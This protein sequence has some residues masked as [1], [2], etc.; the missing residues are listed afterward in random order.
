[1]RHSNLIIILLLTFSCSNQKEITE[2]EKVLGKENSEAL[3]YLVNDFES[4]YLKR[5]YPNIG[6]KKAYSQFLKEL[7]TGQTEYLQNISENSREYFEKST[8]KLEIYSVLDSIWIERNPKKLTSNIN[9]NPTLNIK[10][11][12]LRPDGTYSYSTSISS[13][14]DGETIDEDSIINESQKNWMDINYD[15]RYSLALNAISNKSDFLEDYLKIRDASGKIDPRFI[16]ERML[17]S[18][19]DLNEYLIKRLIITEIVY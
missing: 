18:K 14:Q 17:K 1:M 10:R 7:S 4:D 19:V 11:K 3:T 5:H 6:T 12:Y 8:L 13:F 16:A 15:G 9:S 2:F